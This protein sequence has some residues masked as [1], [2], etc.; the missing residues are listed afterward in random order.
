MTCKIFS[1]FLPCFN[2]SKNEESCRK[3]SA[4]RK[5]AKHNKI[6][7]GNNRATLTPDHHDSS[8]GQCHHSA[9]SVISN[10]ASSA[11]AVMTAIHLSA[12]E[13]A[14]CGSSHG[15]AADGGG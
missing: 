6:S 12:M 9:G 4:P 8:G 13:G 3:K 2:K 5:S 15:E 10:D 11:A 14:G 7:R 1:S